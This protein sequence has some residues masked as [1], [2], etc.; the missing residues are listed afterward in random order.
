MH[1]IGDTVTHFDIE[2]I[3]LVDFYNIRHKTEIQNLLNLF[4]SMCFNKS[5]SISI[6]SPRDSPSVQHI[7]YASI[8]IQLLDKRTL[9]SAFNYW[10][11]RTFFFTFICYIS[12]PICVKIIPYDDIILTWCLSMH[13]PYILVG[14]NMMT[15]WFLTNICI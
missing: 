3:T 1:L 10:T 7:S 2:T 12:W 5:L 4:L 13:G 15:V 11:K 8:N 14:N 6:R 9:L